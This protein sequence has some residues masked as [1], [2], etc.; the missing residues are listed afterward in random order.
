MEPWRW[1]PTSTTCC[2]PVSVLWGRSNPSSGLCRHTHW[3]LWSPPWYTVGLTTVTLYSLVSPTAIFSACNPFSTRPFVWLTAHP[4]GTRLLI[5]FAIIIGFLSSS[6][7]S[8]NCAWLYIHRCLHGEAPR[9]L[10]DLIT[11]SAAATARASLRSTT[12]GSV[13]VPRT[14]SSLSDRSFAVAASGAWNK[15][16]SPLR[17]FDWVNILKC[18]RNIYL[19]P[20]ILA[21][22]VLAFCIGLLGAL[23][24]FRALTSP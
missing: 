8:T 16:P 14:T 15:L 11:P 24:V 12:S 13:A 20:G 7:L 1:G 17:R 2:R 4:G 19:R 3:P 6:V 21:F 22:R 9:Y 18:Q 5:C 10:V 23:V